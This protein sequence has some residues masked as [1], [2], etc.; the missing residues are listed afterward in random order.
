MYLSTSC[1]QVQRHAERLYVE[2]PSTLSRY[3]SAMG[4][5]QDLDIPVGEIRKLV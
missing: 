4:I 5:E 3:N 1:A 2:S